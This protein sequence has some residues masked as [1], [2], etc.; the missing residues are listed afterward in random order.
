MDQFQV[1]INNIITDLLKEGTYADFINLQTNKS[2]NAHTIFL[3]QE[4]QG[5]Q[6]LQLAQFETTVILAENK[7]VPC[8]TEKCENVEEE[9]KKPRYFIDGNK[10]KSKK[11]LC[12][13][14]AIYYIRV[15]NLLAALMVGLDKENNMCNKR[16]V[17]LY[18][19]VDD[20]GGVQ[21]SVCNSDD[22]LYPRDIMDIKGLSELLT[23][24]QQYDVEGMTTHNQ[25]GIEELKTLTDEINRV[26]KTSI[27]EK[28]NTNINPNEGVNNNNNKGNQQ[29]EGGNQQEP[30]EPEVE[31][32][33]KVNTKLKATL[34]KNNKRKK[35]APNPVPPVTETVVIEQPKPE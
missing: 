18:K 10:P 22:T 24:Y 26:F 6:K 27:K 2:C 21:V 32:V 28:G 15:F 19:K 14:I 3:E 31:Q 33:E 29:N 8:T 11:D 12:N 13:G 4:L 16:I 34:A 25:N 17:S 23:L 1:K 7:S 20:M 5:L 9:L 35:N 30:E